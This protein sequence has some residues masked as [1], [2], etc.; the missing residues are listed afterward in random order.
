MRRNDDL[1]LAVRA[2]RLKRERVVKWPNKKF[3][4]AKQNAKKP[5]Y[6]VAPYRSSERLQDVVVQ[7][8]FVMSE[9][10]NWASHGHYLAREG[11]NKEDELGL[12]FD[13]G[14]E[15]RDMAQTLRDWQSSGDERH[16]RVMISP[17]EAGELNLPDY[18]RQVVAK[19]ESDMGMKLEWV[20][21]DHYNTAHPHVHLIVRGVDEKGRM[22][23]MDDDYVKTGIRQRA[24]E[25]ATRHLG[26]RTEQD[27]TRSRERL[28]D[29]E[30]F[31]AIDR[32][33]LK[34]AEDNTVTYENKIP[35][36]TRAQDQR[37]Q[38]MGR[39]QTLAAM[40]L[41]EKTG[42]K[43]WQLS[44]D[45]EVALRQL[46]RSKDVIKTR[47]HEHTQSKQRQFVGR[48]DEIERTRGRS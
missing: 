11:A 14:H 40:G 39:L 18:T 46:Q 22:Y 32:A 35:D 19:M 34:R 3:R 9:G 1:H 28:I 21:I 48:I 27:L 12:G 23:W 30:R 8:S 6:R 43:T 16:W 36:S 38:E 2:G 37:L 20:A 33:I 5:A 10:G 17:G 29:A 31:T 4:A 7:A 26:L 45:T 24:K 47:A 42:P 13:A 25:I 41:A 44:P 15:N